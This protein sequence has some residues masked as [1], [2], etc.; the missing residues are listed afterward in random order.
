MKVGDK[1]VCVDDTNI[2]NILL[3]NIY[4]IYSI[5]DD[6]QFLLPNF[7]CY[8]STRFISMQEYR[9]LKLNTINGK[10]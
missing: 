4:T 6:D 7:G 3:Y 1:V 8:R 2:N 10:R 9:R 5:I